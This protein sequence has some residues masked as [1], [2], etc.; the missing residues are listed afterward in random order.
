MM[1][2][3]SKEAQERIDAFENLMDINRKDISF[4]KEKA[5]FENHRIRKT[6]SWRASV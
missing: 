5:A 2:F 3:V 6:P 4:R 1:K